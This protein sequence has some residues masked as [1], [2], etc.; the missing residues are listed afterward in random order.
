MSF[1]K[2]IIFTGF[3]PNLTT[4]DTILAVKL[5]LM[6]CYWQKGAG[7]KL[8]L[9]SLQ[10]FFDRQEIFLCDSGRSSL[11]IALMAAGVEPGDDVLVQA[12]T[13]LVVINAIRAAGA[14]PVYVEIGRDYNLD[15][16]DAAKKITPKTRAIIVQH[17]FG[18]AAQMPG[19]MA[20]AKK[21]SLKVIE[22]CAHSLGANFQGKLTGT[23]GDI[24]I[25]SFGSDKIISCVRGGA[26]IVNNPSLVE[27][28]RKQIENL[29]D[30][31]LVRILQHLMHYPIF[32]IGKQFYHIFFGKALLWLAKKLCLTNQLVYP[33]EKRGEAMRDYPS[34]L[35]N[36][37]ALILCQQLARL[38]EVIA[39]RRFVAQTYEMEIHNPN[40]ILPLKEIKLVDR[41]ASVYVRYPI[42]VRYPQRL[43]LHMKKKGIL[44]GNWYDAVVSPCLDGCKFT[45]Y[46]PGSCP[47]AERVCKQSANLPT[48]IIIGESEIKRIIEALNSFTG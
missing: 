12:F 47:M 42:L 3:A 8:A 9:T 46:I 32:Y 27:P 10:E 48:D 6:P 39:R 14:R 37:L 26:I 34:R 36:A 25:L 15:V 21:H 33:E 35:P 11:V 19:F 1:F 44:L 17:T 31:K 7:A 38:K 2:K 28:T 43:Y 30:T 20:L 41:F 29:P 4:K 40:I 16:N 23:I 22:D 13:C 5:L 18:V 45:E 24:A